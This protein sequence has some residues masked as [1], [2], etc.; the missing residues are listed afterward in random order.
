VRLIGD[1]P[2]GMWIGMRRGTPSNR[3]DLGTPI[4]EPL[5]TQL[6][7]YARRTVTVTAMTAGETK[8]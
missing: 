2:F 7:R 1:I 4:I 5:Y 8:R 3:R 6:R